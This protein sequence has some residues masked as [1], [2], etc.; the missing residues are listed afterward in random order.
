MIANNDDSDDSGGTLKGWAVP[1]LRV[2]NPC[3]GR[4][5]PRKGFRGAA[6]IFVPTIVSQRAKF[7]LYHET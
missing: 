5:V 2:R 4:G 3:K 1:Q 6:F 7:V